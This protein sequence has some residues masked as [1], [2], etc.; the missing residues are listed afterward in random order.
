[1]NTGDSLIEKKTVLILLL[2]EM[3]LK[4]YELQHCEE[5]YL[6]YRGQELKK[7]DC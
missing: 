7:K 5:M 4:K 3:E 1:V 6:N 2:L